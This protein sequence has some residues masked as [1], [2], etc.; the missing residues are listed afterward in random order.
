[1]S[2]IKK[3]SLLFAV[4]SIAHLSA[5]SKKATTSSG[6]KVILKTDGTWAYAEK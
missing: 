1:M 4:L 3:V 6:E 5:Q 2:F